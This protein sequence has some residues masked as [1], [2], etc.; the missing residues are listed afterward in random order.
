MDKVRT[1]GTANFS[2]NTH[3]KKSL[4]NFP[5]PAGVTLAKLSLGGN[6]LTILFQGEFSQ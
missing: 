2:E 1:D 5:S 4:S 3:C 6:N